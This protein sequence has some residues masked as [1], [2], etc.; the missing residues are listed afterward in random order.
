V[1]GARLLA[2]LE[3]AYRSGDV[4]LF[5]GAFTADARTNDGQ[6]RAVVR[7]TYADIFKRVPGR[8]LAFNNV[9]WRAAGDGR[10]LGSGEVRVSNQHREG[11]GWR[12]A[13]G[14]VEFVLV[15]GSDGYRIAS[16][17]Y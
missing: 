16:M 5:A 2:R 10:I 9:T 12:H 3:Q 15:R 14:R 8:K 6:G 17:S 4:D 13:K 11:G 1:V 7:S